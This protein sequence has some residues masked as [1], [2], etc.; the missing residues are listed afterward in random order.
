VAGFDTLVGQGRGPPFWVMARAVGPSSEC[1]RQ[2]QRAKTAL[3]LGLPHEPHDDLEV[4]QA[5]GSIEEPDGRERA[6]TRGEREGTRAAL[7]RRGPHQGERRAL[8]AAMRD[9]H[10]VHREERA[11]MHDGRAARRGE[12]A[13]CRRERAERRT[14]RAMRREG[15]VGR[16]EGGAVHRA[17]RAALGFACGPSLSRREAVRNARAG[18][19]SAR[20]VRRSSAPSADRTLSRRHAGDARGGWE[21]AGAAT[22][23]GEDARRRCPL[24]RDQYRVAQP[25]GLIPSSRRWRP[26]TPTT[27]TARS[28][29]SMFPRETSFDVIAKDYDAFGRL[30]ARGT[31]RSPT[32]RDLRVR[33]QRLGVSTDQIG[34]ITTSDGVSVTNT[35]DGF[36]KKKTLWASSSVNGSVNWTYDDFFRPSTLQVSSA[37]AITFAYDAD[38]LYIGTSSPVFSVTRDQTGSS[39]DGLPYSSVLGTVSDAWTYDGFGAQS[40]YTVKTSDGTVEYAMSGTGCGRHARSRGMRTGRITSMVEYINGVTHSWAITYDA[41]RKAGERRARWDDH[42][43]RV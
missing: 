31:T 21:P 13:V 37:P 43:L 36:L 34:T 42:D 8:R 15:R 7:A 18:E 14:G 25:R 33:P 30:S 19:P 39:L 26:R 1:R 17:E 10:V 29:P 40:S 9:G 32:S 23:P 16:A 27:R 11:V 4:G 6:A 38:S 41:R 28:P 12:W 20:V 5:R 35:F 22:K 24:F 3:S 2:G